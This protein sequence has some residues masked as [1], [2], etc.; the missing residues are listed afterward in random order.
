MTLRSLFPNEV[1]KFIFSHDS[2]PKDYSFFARNDRLLVCAGYPII[3]GHKKEIGGSAVV[4]TWKACAASFF[5][6]YHREVLSGAD[7]SD[8]KPV[9]VSGHETSHILRLSCQ[10]E[11]EI[12]IT[13]WSSTAETP[14]NHSKIWR[15]A[16]LGG[17]K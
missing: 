1:L 5:T 4:V 16:T 9:N 12:A 2:K 7:R 11:Y 13:A 6:I 8:W 10:K 15:V 3:V 17:N 14:L